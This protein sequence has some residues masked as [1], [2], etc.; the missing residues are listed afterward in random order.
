MLG[1]VCSRPLQRSEIHQALR[2]G[3]YQISLLKGSQVLQKIGEALLCGR[4]NF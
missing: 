3:L 2:L 1:R 4:H